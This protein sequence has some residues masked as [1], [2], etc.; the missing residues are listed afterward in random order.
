MPN[1]T[2]YKNIIHGFITQIKFNI[3][4]KSGFLIQHNN[5]MEQMREFC[6]SISHIIAE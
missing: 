1:S 5:I 6:I 2:I 3:P 4:I